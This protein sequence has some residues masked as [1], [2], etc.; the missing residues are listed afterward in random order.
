MQLLGPLLPGDPGVLEVRADVVEGGHRMAVPQPQHGG[1]VFAE[2]RV[3]RRHHHRLGDGRH[4][5]QHLFDLECADVLA[6]ADDHVGLAVGDG[7]VPIRVEDA[8]VTGVVPPV[9]VEG[10]VGQ[11]VVGVAETEVGAPREDL[12]VVGESDLD[13]GAGIAVG[14]E[15]FVLRRGGP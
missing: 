4:A 7:Q 6:A 12:A 13:A 8:D 1:G 15:A 11:G 5:Q 2:P 14:V 3:G 9:V 10:P